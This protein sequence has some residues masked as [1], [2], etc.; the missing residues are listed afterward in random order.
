M[1]DLSIVGDQIGS[2]DGQNL[3][4]NAADVVQV[5]AASLLRPVV[6]L[7]AGLCQQQPLHGASTAHCL[8]RAAEDAGQEAAASRRGMQDL[9]GKVHNRG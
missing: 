5:S 7:P 3:L 4:L 2:K 9:R 1:F 6:H 8:R